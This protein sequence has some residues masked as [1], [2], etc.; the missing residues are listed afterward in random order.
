[1]VFVAIDFIFTD[2]F[3]H[4]LGRFF[5][6]TSKLISYRKKA[7]FK[8]GWLDHN[9]NNNNNNNNRSCMVAASFS[10]PLWKFCHKKH[11]KGKHRIF[12]PTP[13]GTSTFQKSQPFWRVHSA[14]QIWPW[15]NTNIV[16]NQKNVLIMYLYL[17]LRPP[18][19]PWKHA[20][21]KLLKIWVK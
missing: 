4:E 12:P 15:I 14:W 11:S 3:V 20:G 10:I 19:T 7:P 18:K 6:G 8:R 17:S 13:P 9:N 21:F 1:M 16:S 2:Q 5:F